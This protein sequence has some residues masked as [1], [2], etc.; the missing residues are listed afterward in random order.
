MTL[1]RHVKGDPGDV[2]GDPNRLQQ[3]FWN[4]LSNA[5]KFTPQGGRIEVAV[6]RAAADGRPHARGLGHPRAALRGGLDRE[7]RRRDAPRRLGRRLAEPDLAGV[8]VQVARDA[9]DGLAAAE[10]PAAERCLPRGIE[11][12]GRRGRDLEPIGAREILQA[13][14][15]QTGRERRHGVLLATRP[16]PDRRVSPGQS[17]TCPSGLQARCQRRRMNAGRNA[18][19]RRRLHTGSAGFPAGCG[20][21]ASV[22]LGYNLS[23]SRCPPLRTRRPV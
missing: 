19:G 23:S 4:L 15:Q 14:E 22:E 10:E 13:G 9:V 7:A 11:V 20:W 2:A 18:A 16:G 8:V 5:I 3:V 17:R 1:A 21:A 12:A 6:E